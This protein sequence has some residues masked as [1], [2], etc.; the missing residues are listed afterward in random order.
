MNRTTI[1]TALI[2]CFIGY[3]LIS[4]AP[5]VYAKSLDLNKM[6]VTI[7]GHRGAAGLAPE[8]SLLAIQKGLESGADFIEIDIHLT[9]DGEI[10]V[11]HDP[12]IDRTTTGTGDI[13]DLTYDQIMSYNIVNDQGIETDLKIPTLDQVLS[14]VDGNSNL[15]IEIKRKP[16][17]Y[18]GI[19]AKMIDIIKSHNAEQWT[20]VQSFNDMTLE[21][22]HSLMEDLPLEKLFIFKLWGLP[23]IFDGTFTSFNSKKYHYIQSFNIYHFSVSK[24]LVSKIH[25]MGKKVKIWTI[26]DESVKIP[27]VGIDG[28]ITDRPDQF[29]SLN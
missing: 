14:L 27:D 28:I 4:I 12:K 16:G 6:N 24:S 13:C 25:K 5:K 18:D 8:N 9:K 29:T 21:I 2:T 10:V 26:K 22:T 17:L 19:E 23:I 7:T 20:T 1:Y 3:S 11:C 15:L